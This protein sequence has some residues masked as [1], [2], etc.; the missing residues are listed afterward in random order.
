MDKNWPQ[1][2]KDSGS[3]LASNPC[4]IFWPLADHLASQWPLTC[5]NKLKKRCWTSSGRRLFPHQTLP[6]ALKSQVP[7]LQNSKKKWQLTLITPLRVTKHLT[8]LSHLIPTGMLSRYTLGISPI[9]IDEKTE[10]QKGELTQN[11]IASPKSDL[12]PG[13]PDS[14]YSSLYSWASLLN[15]Q[16][17]FPHL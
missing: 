9:F 4:Q 7:F 15:S 2:Q 3:K 17:Q 1:S 14:K 11:H 8:S 16:T 10:A 12:I 13:L 6:I 5:W